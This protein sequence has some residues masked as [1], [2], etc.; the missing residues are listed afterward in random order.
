[1]KLPNEIQ[2]KIILIYSIE[3]DNLILTQ[4]GPSVAN[5]KLNFCQT[6]AKTYP[7]PIQ[8]H[9]EEGLV[10]FVFPQEQSQSQQ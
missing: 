9:P 1:M 10:D 5:V 4:S 7:N 3:R 8:I 2:Y 6:P